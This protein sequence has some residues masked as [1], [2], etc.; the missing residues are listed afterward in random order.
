MEIKTNTENFE[1]Q[2]EDERRQMK[3]LKEKNKEGQKRLDDIRRVDKDSKATEN[4]KIDILKESH[5]ELDKL[6]RE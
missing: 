6:I 1:K 4:R 2:S 3:A 5:K